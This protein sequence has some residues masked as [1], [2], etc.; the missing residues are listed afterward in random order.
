MYAEKTWNMEK[1][2]VL[3]EYNLLRVFGVGISLTHEILVPI[4]QGLAQAA[5]RNVDLPTWAKRL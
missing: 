3:E 2:K 5:Q 1:Y 4:L